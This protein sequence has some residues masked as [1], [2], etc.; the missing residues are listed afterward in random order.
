MEPAS[1]SQAEKPQFLLG[2]KGDVLASQM[3]GNII[4][5]M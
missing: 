1:V 2:Q 3:V 5:N 4:R